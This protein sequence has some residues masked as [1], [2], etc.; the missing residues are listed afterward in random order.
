MFKQWIKEG[1]KENPTDFFEMP[2]KETVSLVPIHGNNK[3]SYLIN[4]LNG[5]IHLPNLRLWLPKN[6][7]RWLPHYQLNIPW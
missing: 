7:V 3:D 5:S 6:L 4:W 1:A 2:K